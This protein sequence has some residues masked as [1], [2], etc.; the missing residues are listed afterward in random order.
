MNRTNIDISSQS[1]VK[2]SAQNSASIDSGSHNRNGRG[3]GAA[4]GFEMAGTLSVGS[5]E[6]MFGWPQPGRNPAAVPMDKLP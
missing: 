5:S 1:F 3:G 2:Y 4:L 6:D